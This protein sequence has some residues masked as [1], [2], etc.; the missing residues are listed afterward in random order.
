MDKQAAMQEGGNDDQEVPTLPYISAGEGKIATEP[1]EGT[2]CFKNTFRRSITPVLSLLD[3]L[4][5]RS[6]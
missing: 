1:E 2:N 4:I 5:G 6:V 3:D